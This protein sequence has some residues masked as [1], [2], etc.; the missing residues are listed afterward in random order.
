[1]RKFLSRA[2]VDKAIT[3]KAGVVLDGHGYTLKNVQLTMEES[4]VVKNVKFDGVCSDEGSNIYA[5]GVSFTVKNCSFVNSN[6]DAIQATPVPGNEI[7]IDGCTFADYTTETSV[8]KRGIHIE[9][10]YT[11]DG[12]GDGIP[13]AADTDNGIK[14]TITNCHLDLTRFI[15]GSEAFANE[16]VTAG[17]FPENITASG[18]TYSENPEVFVVIDKCFICSYR[19]DN[20]GGGWKTVYAPNEMTIFALAKK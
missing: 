4:S 7:V 14:L 12:D 20:G 8:Q 19:V 5:P 1:M 16:I 13:D 18:N 9:A 6:W 11:A 10:S 15:T 2:I 17:V 3:L